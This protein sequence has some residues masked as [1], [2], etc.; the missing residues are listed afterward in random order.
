[1]NRMAKRWDK[2]EGK[3]KSGR[4]FPTLLGSLGFYTEVSVAPSQVS[5]RALR[6]DKSNRVK[7]GLEAGGN[8]NE[9][10]S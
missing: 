4:G 5:N 2:Q 9:E 8:A 1:M 7:D 10:A 6:L 3:T